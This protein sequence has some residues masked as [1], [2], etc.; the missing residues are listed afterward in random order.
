MSGEFEAKEA[1][2][3]ASKLPT[4][5]PEASEMEKQHPDGAIY[6]LTSGP[7]AGQRFRLRHSRTVAARWV[8]VVKRQPKPK[9]K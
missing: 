8:A 7:S 5:L 1:K 4:D 9:K 6:R 2:Q 3:R